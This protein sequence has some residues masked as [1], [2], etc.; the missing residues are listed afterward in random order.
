MKNQ[1]NVWQ[2]SCPKTLEIDNGCRS[3]KRRRGKQRIKS[4]NTP[5]WQNE[6]NPA[7]A[8]MNGVNEHDK[9]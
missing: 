1:A 2:P 3:T 5:I 6:A 8:A 4:V 7:S 9:Q